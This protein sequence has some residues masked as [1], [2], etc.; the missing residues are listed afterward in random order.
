MNKFFKGFYHAFDGIKYAFQTQINMRFHLVVGAIVIVAG[1]I[2]HL[3][4][5]EWA[6]IALSITLVLSAEL[7]NTAIE[8]LTNLA[9]KE[10]HP[11]AK[12]AKDCAA[13]AVLI[14]AIFAIIIGCLVFIPHL[15]G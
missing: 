13:G 9:T 12:V 6:F 3:T 15:I 5:I 1:I 2:L 7:F 8:S 11:L 10:I 14:T 4:R